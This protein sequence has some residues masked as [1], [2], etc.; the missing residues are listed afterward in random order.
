MASDSGD[1]PKSYT[2]TEAAVEM[3]LTA[4]AVG[5]MV[6][7]EKF[8]NAYKAGR[9]W[10]IPASDI[11]QW[12]QEQSVAAVRP[13]DAP[14]RWQQFK[15]QPYIFWPSLAIGAFVTILTLLFALISA[16]ADLGGARQQALE[17]GL[18]LP[19][20]KAKADETLIVIAAFHR[21][22]GVMDTNAH[23]EIHRA[24]ANKLA[25]LDNHNIRAEIEPRTIESRDR[26]RAEE[27]GR[28]H[29]AA[30]IVWGADTGARLEVNFLNLKE[31]DFDA[32]EVTISE[33]IRTQ[34][35]QPD[36]YNQ[37]IINDLPAQVSFLALFT[38]G[39]SFYFADNYIEALRMMEAAI[40][41]LEK[42]S[43]LPTG[44]LEAYFRL[45]WLQQV[46]FRNHE[47]ASSSYTR[48][49]ELDPNYVSAYN[50]RGNARYHLGDM[51]GAIA[52]YTKAIELDPKDAFAYSNRGI[53]RRNLGDLAGAI[54]DYNKA[55]ELDPNYVYAY[56]NRGNARSDL[57][58]LAGAIADYNKAIELDP[59]YVYAYNNRGNA[60]S[61]LG[62]LA[63]AITDYNK[64]IELDPNDA[65][66]YSNRGI[67]RLN[68]GDLAG[69]ITDYN[70]AIELDPNYVYAYN[71]R[72]NARYYLGDLERAMAD[73][74]KAIELD[75]KYVR[76]FH[77]RCYALYKLGQYQEALP[78]CETAVRLDPNDADFLDSR[79]FIYKALG[80][81]A[82]AIADFESILE[83]TNDPFL[84]R[85][86]QEAL[87][88]LRP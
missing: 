74:T 88:E 45:G 6:R 68:L 3:G 43:N 33:T 23:G 42:V 66:A 85:R 19:F 82:E 41:E 8:P 18:I 81:R 16:G 7:A 39:Q 52:D 58:D 53:V 56:S 64:A 44:S 65:F 69:A 15:S 84:I 71:N 76:A 27:I 21:S 14:T 87:A 50:N 67:V 38:I 73:Y 5:E 24:I 79:A 61:D 78:D 77:G 63:G 32:A 86:A 47:T 30:I 80:R 55:I 34:L 12:R 1:Q 54:T 48:A 49:I 9:H 36:A 37:L 20:S 75:P 83:L 22:A 29:N 59:N 60:R 26:A 51:E 62:D 57:G 31:P 17:W 10:R 72:G 11:E 40:V 4:A 70:K 35:A 28:Q 25:E 2:T 13:F 46:P